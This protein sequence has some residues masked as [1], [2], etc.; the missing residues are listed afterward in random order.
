MSNFVLHSSEHRI[1]EGRRAGGRGSRVPR[2]ELPE[3]IDSIEW[4]GAKGYMATAQ[5]R[6]GGTNEKESLGL[7]GCCKAPVG[8]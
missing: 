8:V 3:E 5:Q 6:V 1:S 4:E 2:Q 7:L